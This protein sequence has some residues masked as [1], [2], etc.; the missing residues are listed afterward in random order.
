MIR[1]RRRAQAVK[2][3]L[4]D[5]LATEGRGGV[6]EMREE[7]KALLVAGLYRTSLAEAF[8]WPE[9]LA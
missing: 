8:R 2:M 6:A 4:L 1:P 9:K 7:K 3:V 5:L